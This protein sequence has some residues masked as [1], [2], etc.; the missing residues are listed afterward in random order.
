M[1]MRISIIEGRM[2]GRKGCGCGEG[3]VGCAEVRDCGAALVILW[4]VGSGHVVQDDSDV[5]LGILC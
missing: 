3:R 4:R 1:C 2:A 5:A